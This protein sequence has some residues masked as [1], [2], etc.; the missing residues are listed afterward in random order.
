M[1]CNIA[2]RQ[3]CLDQ[4]KRQAFE[5]GADAVIAIDLD[6]NEATTGSGSGSG[7]LFVA[8]TGTAVRLA[9]R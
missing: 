7:I 4:L 3:A 8:A 1:S 6:Y 5:I 2:Q 9:P